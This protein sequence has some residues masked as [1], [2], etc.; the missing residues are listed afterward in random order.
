VRRAE[1]D[2]GTRPGKT[3]AELAEIRDL[4]KENAELRRANEILKAAS[5]FL[6]GG[7]RPPTQVL[8]AF[9]DEHKSDVRGRADLSRAQQARDQ[10]RPVDL[11][12]GQIPTA[13]EAGPS[14][15][16]DPRA[17]RPG[18]GHRSRVGFGARKMWLHLRRN[19]HGRG[20]VQPWSG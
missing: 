1:V 19:G 18:R 3:S 15:R 9:I 2:G 8:T 13:I 7:A 16:R 4:K 14:R 12:R 6:R 10:D 17:D 5:G 11:L 20:P